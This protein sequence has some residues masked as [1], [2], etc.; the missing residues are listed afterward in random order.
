MDKCMPLVNKALRGELVVPNFAFLTE[1]C[2]GLFANM[3]N[4]AREAEYLSSNE[5]L[6][7]ATID[8]QRLHL[9]KDNHIICADEIISVVVMLVAIEHLGLE[10]VKQFTSFEPSGE[11]THAAEVNSEGL[12][13]NPFMWNGM[14]ALCALL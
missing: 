2:E 14:L 3:C 11:S 4:E 1:K 6:D 5:T 8:G 10:S 9:G 7:V 13:F 12:P